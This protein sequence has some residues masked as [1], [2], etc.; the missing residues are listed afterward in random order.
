MKPLS[1]YPPGNKKKHGT[2]LTGSDSIKS[3][4]QK[5]PQNGMGYVSY[6]KHRGLLVESPKNP[7]FSGLGIIVIY[8]WLFLV[9]LSSV[10][11]VANRPSPNWQVCHTTYMPLIVL[12]FVWGLYNPYHPLEEPE[13]SAEFT[14]FFIK[15]YKVG[16]LL[17]IQ[18]QKVI[19]RVITPVTHL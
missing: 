6:L 8:Q 11:S 2:H 19:S 18:K 5:V 9:P 10:G 17:V 4:T 15:T 7:L 16:P 3:S 12:A 13:K 14:R 1:D